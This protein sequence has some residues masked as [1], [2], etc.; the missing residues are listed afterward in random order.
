MPNKSALLIEKDGLNLLRTQHEY[1][2]MS[3]KARMA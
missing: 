2:L 3:S 1:I